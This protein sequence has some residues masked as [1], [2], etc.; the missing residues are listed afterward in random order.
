MRKLM[1]ALIVSLLVTGLT[2]A[3]TESRMLIHGTRQITDSWGV[4]GWSVF[5]N[6]VSGTANLSVI[7]S[8]YSWST[9][10]VELLSGQLMANGSSSN[11][12]NMRAFSKKLPIHFWG[13]VEYF[14]QDKTLYWFLQA[15][16]PVSIVGKFIGKIGL[17][18]ENV[19]QPGM[20]S[21]LGI[22]PHVIVSLAN[23]LTMIIAHQ[24]KADKSQFSRV[25]LVMDF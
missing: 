23:N 3:Q 12:V 19:H 16:R 18:T 6:I 9:G 24:W 8:R 22:G 7:G 11:L 2:Q 4:A 25:Y 1:A 21:Q 13:E 15:D 17:E 10:W 5:P 14:P 20:I